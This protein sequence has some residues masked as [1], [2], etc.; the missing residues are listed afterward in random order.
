MIEILLQRGCVEEAECY[1]AEFYPEGKIIRIEEDE[2]YT[3]ILPED[4]L[5]KT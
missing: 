5:P 3:L 1:A 2:R 4:K